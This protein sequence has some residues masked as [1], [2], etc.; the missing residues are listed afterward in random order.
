M[1]KRLLLPLLMLPFAF[2]ASAQRGAITYDETVKI[3]IELPPEMESMRDQIP[4]SN[5]TSR[6]LLFNESAMLMKDAPKPEKADNKTV[7]LGGDGMVFKMGM[8]RPETLTYSNL[9]DGVMIEKQDFLGR[10]FRITGDMPEYQWRLTGE[11]SEYLGYACQKAVAE[12]DS[13][14]IEA[15]FTSEIPVSAG[16]AGLNGLPGMILVAS[17]DDG[18][19]MITATEVVMDA[20]EVAAIEPPS[21]GKEVTREE[22]DKIVEEKMK[23]MGASRG[24][25]GNRM[26]IS[27][28]H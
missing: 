21:G 4:S 10:V 20:P 15:W 25:G 8:D 11:Q 1:M 9:D 28:K 22:Y 16:P 24:R 6:L 7:T 26:M 3:E 13:T 17:F 23:E 12:K 14:M 19:R 5:T 2:S 27:I 18:K